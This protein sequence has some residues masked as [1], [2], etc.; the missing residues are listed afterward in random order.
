MCSWRFTF[1]PAALTPPLCGSIQKWMATG[2][3]PSQPVLSS[4]LEGDL[5]PQAPP[6]AGPVS[7]LDT[8][9]VCL[10]HPPGTLCASL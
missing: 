1:Y 10:S 2:G 3:A 4:F 8:A 6:S 7:I 9:T 5:S